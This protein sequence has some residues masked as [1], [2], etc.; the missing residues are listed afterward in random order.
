M[1]LQGYN[2]YTYP[3]GF[4]SNE[5]HHAVLSVSGTIHTLYLDGVQVAQNTSSGN[6]F[7]T[8]TSITNTT[9]GARMNKTQGFRG[10]IGETRMYNYVIN[11]TQVAS[12]YRDRNLVVYYP[13]DNSVNYLT[14][15]YATLIYDAS[16]IG[17]STITTVTANRNVGSGALALTNV[18]PNTKKATQYVYS[19]PGIKGFAPLIL[20]P[21]SGFTVACWINTTGVAGQIMRIFDI[22]AKIGTKGLSVDISGTNMIYSS[23]ISTQV[24][25]GLVIYYPFDTNNNDIISGTNHFVTTTATINT[26]DP[27]PIV[28]TGYL[29]CD[30]KCLSH[31]SIVSFTQLSTTALSYSSWI[32]FPTTSFSG[33]TLMNFFSSSNSTAIYL[34][35]RATPNTASTTIVSIAFVTN[36]SPYQQYM[37]NLIPTITINTWYHI[38]FTINN[39]ILNIYV[40]GVLFNGC[41]GSVLNASE[42]SITPVSFPYTMTYSPIR[43]GFDKISIGSGHNGG[44]TSRSYHDDIRFYNRVLTQSDV[45]AIYNYKG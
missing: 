6:V 25:D 21:S 35:N 41:S 37:F 22:P 44:I 13:F 40:N 18:T 2:P 8:Y 10:N 16:L 45:T 43:F 31:S 33:Q 36:G 30:G 39:N 4:K 29:N 28:G 15:N 14:P 7:T 19:I 24:T 11:P 9:I 38:A 26:S 3:A 1:S 23:S 20:D 12:L 32:S 27:I 42:S 5:F 17:Q 34:T